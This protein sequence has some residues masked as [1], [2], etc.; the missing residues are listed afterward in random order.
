VDQNRGK[1]IDI[2]KKGRNDLN[3]SKPLF[4]S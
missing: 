3:I 4:S 2:H 1:S